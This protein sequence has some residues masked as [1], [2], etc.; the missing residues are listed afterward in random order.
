MLSVL[1]LRLSSLTRASFV[2]TLASFSCAP[3][4]RV[5]QRA[6]EEIARGYQYLARQDEERADV[7]FAHALAFN[8]DTPEALNGAGVVA[9][10]R[11]DLGEARR[12]FEHAVRVAPDFAEAYV[13]LGELDLAEGRTGAA[14][15]DFR[16]ALGIDPDLVVARLDL[17]RTLLHRG[18]ADPEQRDAL[19]ARAR[20]EYLHLL[21]S[22]ELAEAHHDL[23]FMDYEAGRWDGAA[24]SYLRAVALAPRYVE[25]LHGVCISLARAGRCDTATTACRT[26]LEIAPA[27]D[28]CAASLR[29]VQACHRRDGVN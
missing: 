14:E 19:W 2:L 6:S 27:D 11:G 18:L 8:E 21:E 7:A 25:A 17:A 5:H 26:C 20:R 24:E 23:G 29:A 13:N 3:S 16:T 22:R 1:R 12:R 10:R 28:R 15:T 4:L 9:R